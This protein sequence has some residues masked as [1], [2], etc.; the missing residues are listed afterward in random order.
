M[1]LKSNMTANDYLVDYVYYRLVQD[2]NANR[3]RN[4]LPVITTSVASDYRNK[5]V[6]AFYSKETK[7][8]KYADKVVK[9]AHLSCDGLIDTSDLKPSLISDYTSEF[10]TLASVK[11]DEHIIPISPYIPEVRNTAAGLKTGSRLLALTGDFEESTVNGVSKSHLKS[12]S[13]YNTV[14]DDKS[15]SERQYYGVIRGNLEAL[16]AKDATAKSVRILQGDEIMSANDE[17]GLSRLAPYMTTAEYNKI[18]SSGW[19]N[20]LV[21]ENAMPKSALDRSVAVLAYM[22][23]NGIDYTVDF[24]R[25]MGQLKASI[26]GTKMAVRLTDT[27][28]NQQYIGCRVYDDGVATYYSL[29]NAYVKNTNP[30]INRAWLTAELKAEDVTPEDAVNLLRYSLGDKI[31]N[32]YGTIGEIG[33]LEVTNRTGTQYHNKT[34]S[35][36]GVSMSFARK[37]PSYGR[38]ANLYIRQDAKNRGSATSD[39]N[40][41]DPVEVRNYLAN[42]V[43]SAKVNYK[44]A[45]DMDALVAQAVEHATEPEYVPDYSSDN[46]IAAEQAEIWGVLTANQV[47]ENGNVV[48]GYM[49]DEAGARNALDSFIENTVGNFD[50]DSEGKRFNPLYVARYMSSDGSVFTNN[51]RL[52]ATMRVCDI[53]AE[54]VRGDEFYNDAVRNAMIKYN[55]DNAVDMRT[56]SSPFMQNIY[57]AICDSLEVNGITDVDVKIDENGIVKYSGTRNTKRE[58]AKGT[59][60][61]TGEIGQIFEPDDLGGVETHFASDN[62]YVFVPGYS[63][64]IIPQKA[65]ENKPLEERTRLMGYEQTL[66]RNIK[67]TIHSDLL[68][69]SLTVG[70]TTNLNNTYRH[71]YDTRHTIEEYYDFSKDEENKELFKLRVKTEAGRV[72]FGNKIKTGSV[73]GQDFDAKYKP[74][75]FDAQNDNFLNP[76]ILTG[77][78]N[79]AVLTEESDGYFDPYMTGTA[80]NQGVVRYLCKGTQINPD[81]SMVKA[82]TDYSDD[83]PAAQ[84]DDRAPLMEAH[85]LRNSQF[86]PFD[87]NQM[88]TSQL[89]TAKRVTGDIGVAQMTFGGWTMDDA[90]VVSKRFA[91]EYQ[92]NDTEGN[93]RSLTVGDKISDMNGNKGVISLV[94][95]PDMSIEEAA[96][97]GIEEPVKWFKNNPDMDVV[98]APFAAVGRFN[99]GSVRTLMEKHYNIEGDPTSGERVTDL[100]GADGTVHEGCLGYA[101]FIITDMPVD[102][103]THEYGESE[104]AQGKGRKASSQLAW[105]LTARGCSNILDELYSTNNSSLKNVREYLVNMGLDVDEDGNLRDHYEPHEG[106]V[107]KVFSIPEIKYKPDKPNEVSNETLNSFANVIANEGGILELP[108]KLTYPTGAPLAK[109]CD[110]TDNKTRE[111]DVNYKKQT[112]TRT[113]KDGTVITCHRNESLLDGTTKSTRTISANGNPRPDMYAFPV[114]SSYMRSGNE[115]QDGTSVVHDYTAQYINIYK[116]AVNYLA[117][118]EHGADKKTLDGFARSA[119]ASYNVITNDVATR[120]FEGKHNIF[121]DGLMANRMPHSATAVWTPDPRLDIDQIAVSSSIADTLGVKNDD[122]IMTWRDPVLK[123]GGVRYMRVKTDENIIGCAINPAMDK[124][125]DGDF[126]GDSIGLLRLNPKNKLAHLEAIAKLSVD[127]NML[128]RGEGK[129]GKHPLYLNDGLDIAAAEYVLNNEPEKLDAETAGLVGTKEDILNTL[130]SLEVGHDAALSEMNN[131]WDMYQ[132]GVVKDIV[133]GRAEVRQEL[134]DYIKSLEKCEYG[135][136]MICFKSLDDYVQSAEHMVEDGAKGSYKKLDNCYRYMGISVQRGEDGRYIKGTASEPEDVI[137]GERLP[138]TLHT[139]AED[140]GTEYATSVR[141]QGTGLAG[142]VAQ[143]AASALRDKGDMQAALE[144]TYVVTQTTLQSKHDPVQAEVV[145]KILQ[146]SGKD[147]WEGR[148]MHWTTDAKGM[149]CFR[150]YTPYEYAKEFLSEDKNKMS[151]FLSKPRTEQLKDMRITKEEFIDNFNTVYRSSENPPK[152]YGLGFDVNEA[153]VEKVADAMIDKDGLIGSISDV[154]RET[155]DKLAYNGDFNTIKELASTPKS[156]GTPHNLYDGEWTY[157][158]A[159]SVIKFNNRI[160]NGDDDDRV[161][162]ALVKSDTVVREDKDTKSVT[163]VN[164]KPN[165][166]VDASYGKDSKGNRRMPDVSTST[167]AQS[168]ATF[169]NKY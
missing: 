93:R 15:K 97:K 155:L 72:T 48:D 14:Y 71:L 167:S 148:K 58:Y 81:G 68:S 103:K 79:M 154:H 11:G 26:V 165:K 52:I 21:G 92:I 78:R 157:H 59:A 156:D 133:D 80:T 147:V 112:W 122:Y 125:Y 107:R 31:E 12:V 129:D 132:L 115:M 168:E 55:P 90:Y 57:S 64:Y 62:N 8:M 39:I 104:V 116:Q 141:A 49:P 162:K 160:G 41:K 34:Y 118:Y 114:M 74:E 20:G 2:A 24:D 126:D 121:R 73:T 42:A 131:S 95:D 128:N 85:C 36:N 87:R 84:R 96:E 25:N 5:F 28:N 108:F 65:G 105:A 17:S 69:P 94:V 47:D 166:T 130:N 77:Q 56:K 159:P 120:K 66:I 140:M 145:Y 60:T 38:N 153:L 164:L 13:P 46:F 119:Q 40:L 123:D 135:H 117:A 89:M 43:N 51:A 7:G 70:T 19:L 32:E 124:S 111:T 35:S 18:V 88:A 16:R 54:E 134:S 9:A 67:S 137:S 161:K 144:A 4:D 86:N 139:R 158:F 29:S 149:D 44:T 33:R 76:Y 75:L 30:N 100:V 138:H 106:E 63:A 102:E 10:M 37:A 136:D 83:V 3:S 50:P 99:G 146:I 45:F 82:N 1:I 110:A 143:K 23:E 27:P 142:T 109:L 113:L 91:D 61:V 53:T 101:P 151:E 152:G 6:E 163:K 98:G 150:A 127:A 169:N 22:A